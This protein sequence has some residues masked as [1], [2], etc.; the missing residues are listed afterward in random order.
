MKVRT[1]LAATLG[2]A[3]LASASLAEGPKH[4][5]K[6]PPNPAFEKMK[7]LVGEWEAKTADGSPVT[8]TYALISD[9]TAL[10]ET[11]GPPKEPTMV[12][13]YNADGPG[14]VLVTHYCNANNQPRMR[15]KA[16]Q[17]EIKSL[18]F[19]FV[20]VSNLN[21]SSPGHMHHLTVTFQDADHFSQ[22]WTW[23]DKGKEG[24]EVF[25]YTRKKA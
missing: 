5:A 3:V 18:S 17:G 24:K 19:D 22:E 14:A 16:P 4:E 21:P 1:A 8:L 2:I 13:M 6:G 10:M 9:A 7:T 11:L 20:D 23:N 12:T 15:A 25:Q